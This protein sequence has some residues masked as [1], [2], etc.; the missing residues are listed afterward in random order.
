MEIELTC[1]SS[2][3]TKRKRPS[4]ET[5]YVSKVPKLKIAMK[6]FRPST[7]HC[8]DCNGMLIPNTKRKNVRAT[9]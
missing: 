6:D 3:C 8:P 9:R 5:A 2:M 4:G 1:D 7:H